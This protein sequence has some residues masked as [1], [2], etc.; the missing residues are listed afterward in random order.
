VGLLEWDGKV[1]TYVVKDTKADTLQ[2]IMVDNVSKDSTVITDA[3]NSYKG[4]SKMYTHIV[5]KHTNGDYKTIGEK[6]T[7][8]IEGFW[9]LLKRGIIGI[10]HYV[11]P[12][13]LHRYCNEFGYRYNE[14]KITD[15][16][17]FADTITKVGNARITYQTLIAEVSE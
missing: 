1:V 12:K 10:Y 4:L 2:P 14:R 8:N 15:C 17:R 11:S 7:N 9:S 16:T 13:H 5:V 3:Y 6:H